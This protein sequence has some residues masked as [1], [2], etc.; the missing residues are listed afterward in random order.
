M[1][2][3]G[4]EW[5]L[6][7]LQRVLNS[8]KYRA[9][10]A[11]IHRPKTDVDVEV[12]RHGSEYGGWVICPSSLRQDS[13]VYSLGV[14]EDVTFDLAMIETYGLEV[15][16]FDPTPKAVEWVERH[17]L[18]ESFRFFPWGVAVFNGEAMFQPPDNP[19]HA[20]YRID[21]HASG[22][23]L[24]LPVRRLG[25]IMAEL[26]HSRLDVLKMDI[27][28]AEFEVIRDFLDSRIEIDQLVVE[29]HPQ[30]SYLFG[31]SWRLVRALKQAGFRLFAV[32]D[33]LCE[34]SFL[35]ERRSDV[36]HG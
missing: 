24:R 1:S 34:Y 3:A 27:E 36:F 28:G 17:D 5:W 33:R 32:S 11:A 16:A 14:G 10:Q 26:G 2:S 31:R 13:I 25:T 15:F 20:S 35:H 22:G 29:V 18:P 21:A 6:M 23:S 12:V 19:E 30:R 4:I 9:L 7:V 8:I